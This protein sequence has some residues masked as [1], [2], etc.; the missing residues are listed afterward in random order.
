MFDPRTKPHACAGTVDQPLLTPMAS[1]ISPVSFE[2]DGVAD[3][4]RLWCG[5]SRQRYVFS[6]YAAQDCPA[7]ENAV[8]ILALVA[9]TGQR[10][11][12]GCI[13]TG[14]IPELAM[15]ALMRSAKGES[16]RLEIH[17][18]LCA[19]SQAARHDL[20]RDLGIALAA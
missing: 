10:Q 11:A 3:N 7:Y 13:D 16:G 17:V 9:E 18:H 12:L 6:V 15:S 5:S 4:F 1:N 8:A 2:A 19:R 14:A 20:M